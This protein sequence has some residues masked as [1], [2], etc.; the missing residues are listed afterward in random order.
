MKCQGAL[1]RTRLRMSQSA[2]KEDSNC[3]EY[4]FKQIQDATKNFCSSCRLGEGGFGPVYKGKLLHTIVAI[5][6]LRKVSDLL[7]TY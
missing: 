1:L 6:Q 5:K 7:I 3:I 2:S 4:R